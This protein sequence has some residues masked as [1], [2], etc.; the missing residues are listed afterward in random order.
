MFKL[1]TIVGSVSCKSMNREQEAA[2]ELLTAGLSARRPRALSSS[3]GGAGA[4]EL[5]FVMTFACLIP[6]RVRTSTL[7]PPFHSSVGEGEGEDGGAKDEASAS[8]RMCDGN[9]R[10]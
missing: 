5:T 6:S 2:D 7:S 1:P 10:I 3:L 9:K 8:E 4:A